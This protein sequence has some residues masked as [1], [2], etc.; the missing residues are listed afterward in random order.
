M[1]KTCGVSGVSGDKLCNVMILIWLFVP[2]SV[3]M[4]VVTAGSAGTTGSSSICPR[5]VVSGDKAGTEAGT[6]KLCQLN[7]FHGVSPL[8]PLT[9]QHF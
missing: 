5:M 3:C 9:P 8:T 2:A 4:P 1:P 7:S 6:G